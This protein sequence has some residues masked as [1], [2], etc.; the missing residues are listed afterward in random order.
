M[1]AEAIGWVYRHSPFRG[2]TFLVHLAIADSVN[3]VH[4]NEFWMARANLATKARVSGESV[5][6]A[7]ETLREAG[8]VIPTE[9]GMDDPDARKRAGR[10]TR[11]LFLFPDDAAVVYETRR[12]GVADQPRPPSRVSREGSRVGRDVTQIEP[13]DEP[14]ARA[15]RVQGDDLA[16]RRARRTDARA[17]DLVKTWWEAQ[18]PRPLQPWPAAVGIVSRALGKGWTPDEITE[19]L[20]GC[21]PPLS[22]GMLDGT[23]RRVRGR[24][25]IAEARRRLDP[26][27]A[28]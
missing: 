8:Y 26:G 28:G 24:A 11:W 14:N 4:G 12:R 3:D 6:T 17:D 23:L 2:A 21:D 7:V 25:H 27:Q 1:S 13:N 15:A 18:D 9:D 19:A 20:R 5:S 16:N 22:G 10:P